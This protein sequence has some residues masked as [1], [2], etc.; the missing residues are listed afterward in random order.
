MTENK[1]GDLYYNL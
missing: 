1:V